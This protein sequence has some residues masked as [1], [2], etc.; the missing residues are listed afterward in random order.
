MS[1]II[2]P[3]L[4]ELRAP[5]GRSNGFNLELLTLAM[6]RSLP[7]HWV[8]KPLRNKREPERFTK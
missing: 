8:T 1:P 2:T 6:S 7:D 5:E 4:E 3:T